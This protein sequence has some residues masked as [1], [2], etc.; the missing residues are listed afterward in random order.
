VLISTGDDYVSS[1]QSLDV[2]NAYR[3]TTVRIMMETTH[4][5]RRPVAALLGVQEF[6]CNH[7]GLQCLPGVDPQPEAFQVPWRT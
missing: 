1:K 3:G 5:Q 6:L 2:A 4:F 7:C